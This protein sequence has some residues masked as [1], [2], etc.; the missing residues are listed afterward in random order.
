MIHFF[1]M[2][3]ADAGGL[4]MDQAVTVAIAYPWSGV[5]G[6]LSAGGADSYR[7]G[8]SI[9]VTFAMTGAAAGVTD[10]TA[11]LY[12]ARIEGGTPGAEFEAT[13]SGASNSGNLFRYDPTSGQYVYNLSTSGL[14]AG[15]Y[16]LRVDLGDGVERAVLITLR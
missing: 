1:G 5:T 11:R 13:A 8:S 3:V 9:P 2:R 15:V 12:L 6:K 10:A 14:T 16:R 7:L 4:Y